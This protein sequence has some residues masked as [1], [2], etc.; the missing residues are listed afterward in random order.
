[1]FSMVLKELNTIPLIFNPQLEIKVDLDSLY[2]GDASLET[3]I[4]MTGVNCEYSFESLR[5]H[6]RSSNSSRQAILC[7]QL[8]NYPISSRGYKQKMIRFH[9]LPN[10]AICNCSLTH[11]LG[12]RMTIYISLTGIEH[13]RQTNYLYREEMAV[14]NTAMNLT[15]SCLKLLS[16][17]ESEEDNFNDQI[18]RLT[19]FDQSVK[20]NFSKYLS[21]RVSHLGPRAMK[22]FAYHFDDFLLSLLEE[23]GVDNCMNPK[24]NGM[25]YDENQCKL[26]RDF[27]ERAILSINRGHHFT[28]NLA[29]FKNAYKENPDYTLRIDR[30]FYRDI[31]FGTDEDDHIDP[32]IQRFVDGCV[33]SL[34]EQLRTDIVQIVE[35]SRLMYYFDIGVD[36]RCLDPNRDLVCHNEEALTCMQTLLQIP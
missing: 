14:I 20:G 36:I 7:N 22:L 27:V 23:G 2:Y 13:I 1:M 12:H 11:A 33:R 21:N 5:T 17:D 26:N 30:Q 9:R 32:Y 18:G 15:S 25:R 4:D 35:D 3:L 31:E 10:V 6:I 34:Y 16:S 29:G 19:S 8:L 28:A 24:F